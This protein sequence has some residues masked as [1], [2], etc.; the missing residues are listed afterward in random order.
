[1]WQGEGCM[2][3]GW[4]KRGASMLLGSKKWKGRREE[5]QWCSPAMER[6]IG[7]KRINTKRVASRECTM[8]SQLEGRFLIQRAKFDSCLPRTMWEEQMVLVATEDVAQDLISYTCPKASKIA[9]SPTRIKL[10]NF[11]TNQT[12]FRRSTVRF[13]HCQPML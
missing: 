10:P 2:R 8:V 7:Y 9:F 13:V 4:G 12:W 6:W 5:R 1:M 11:D 3:S